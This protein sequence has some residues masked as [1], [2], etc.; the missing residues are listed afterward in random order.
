MKEL[1]AGEFPGV[2]VAF[3]ALVGLLIGSFLNVCIYR[4]PRDISVV[5]PRS[6][7][8][9]CERAI[10][11]LDNIPL[12]SFLLLRGKCRN[13]SLPI[14]VR[15][16]MVEATTAVLF[17]AT[18]ARYEIS[19]ATLKWLL[20]E[21]I[22]IV[23]FWIDLEERILPDELTIGGIVAG[24]ICAV[25]VKLPG[26]LTDL[27]VPGWPTIAQSIV[28]S[29][30]GG[31]LL[32][33]SI[34]LLGLIYLRV[35]KQEGVGFGDV[36]LLALLG[37]FLGLEAGIQ[38][39]LI[40]ALSGTVFGLGFILIARKDASTYELPFGSFLCLGGGLLPLLTTLGK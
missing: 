2:Y 11:A 37:S 17:G 25:F 29:A 4:I 7:C 5:R 30:L 3:V 16:P 36:K 24:L 23:L 33:G 38:A 9:G 20:F 31:A 1:L 27:L 28:N 6:F 40:G 26:L 19:G 8:P 12:L 32:G 34:W 35:R 13:C 15:Y 39:L 10:G 14:G 18:A 21:S 22:L